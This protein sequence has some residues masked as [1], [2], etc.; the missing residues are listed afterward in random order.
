[1]SKGTNESKTVVVSLGLKLQV[2]VSLDF[3][4]VFFLF[5]DILI[6]SRHP[7]SCAS[8]ADIMAVLFFDKLRLCL[9]FPLHKSSD[10]FV[11]SKGHAAPILYAGKM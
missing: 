1:M 6:S 2:F 4:G 11:L 3:L 10:R 8:I 5:M 9:D 7:T